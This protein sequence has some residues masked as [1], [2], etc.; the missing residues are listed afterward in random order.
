MIIAIVIPMVIAQ[1]YIEKAFYDLTEL[2]NVKKIRID[3]S[4]KFFTIDT[5]TINKNESLHYVTGRTGGRNN[6][7]LTYYLYMACPFKP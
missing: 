3:K 4:E 7:R 6:E 2:P 1:S 5:F